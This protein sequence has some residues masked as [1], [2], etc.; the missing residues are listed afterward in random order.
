MLK[1][2]CEHVSFISQSPFFLTLTS[3]AYFSG[4]LE[5]S[6]SLLTFA[7]KS[8]GRTNKMGAGDC[9]HVKSIQVQKDNPV[10][11]FCYTRREQKSFINENSNKKSTILLAF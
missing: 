10:V 3:G 11:L 8:W 6:P 2:V 9:M 5:C 1:P 7:T 4:V